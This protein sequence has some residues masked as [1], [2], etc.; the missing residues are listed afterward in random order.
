MTVQPSASSSNDKELKQRNNPTFSSKVFGQDKSNDGGERP[1]SRS[2]K[3]GN[4]S[5]SVFASAQIESPTRKHLAPK[6][7]GQQKLFGGAK[8]DYENK[9]NHMPVLGGKKKSKYPASVR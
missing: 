6:D 1:P 7:S 8:I 3:E 4:W 5:S 2:R 9:S